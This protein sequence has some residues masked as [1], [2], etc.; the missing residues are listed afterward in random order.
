MASTNKTTYYEL[1]QYVG[2]DKPTYLV[3][4]NSDMSKI[5]AG[6]HGVDEK[7]ETNEASIGVLSSLTTTDKSSLVG[8]VN[9]VNGNISGIGNLSNLTTTDKSSLVGAVNEVN[10]NVGVLSNLTT[11]AKSNT[12]SAINEVDGKV[13]SN[14]SDIGDLNNLT[15]TVKTSLVGASNELKANI[16]NFNLTSFVTLPNTSIS[17]SG[18]TINANSFVTVAKNSDGS[19]GKIY[20]EIAI[21]NPTSTVNITVVGSG[22]TPSSDFTINCAGFCRILSNNQYIPTTFDVTLRTNGNIEISKNIGTNVGQVVFWLQPYL[23]F[24]KDFGDVP[25]V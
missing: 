1:S 19:L 16:D 8:A 23:Y 13:A 20:G 14:T 22:L 6:I 4:Y 17:S 24:I 12:V 2:S 9:E 21:N 7:A 18:N 5:D 15:T 11:T 25:I 10:G 3:D